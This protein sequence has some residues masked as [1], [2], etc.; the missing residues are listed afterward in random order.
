MDESYNKDFGQV[1][2]YTKDQENLMDLYPYYFK[3]IIEEL[4]KQNNLEKY[5]YFFTLIHHIY[6]SFDSIDKQKLNIC[7][8]KYPE[9]I[10]L[11]DIKND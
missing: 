9:L 4:F 8:V 3:K 10:K 2:S 1:L 7:L 6:I 5:H 11:L